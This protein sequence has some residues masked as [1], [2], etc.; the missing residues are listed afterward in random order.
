MCFDRHKCGT[1][2]ILLMIKGWKVLKGTLMIVRDRFKFAGL[3]LVLTFICASVGNAANVA[4]SI[5]EDMMYDGT[6]TAYAVWGNDPSAEIS[7]ARDGSR[8]DGIVWLIDLSGSGHKVND[9]PGWVF[10]WK[11]IHGPGMY[12]NLYINDSLH[13]T[14][15]SGW[16]EATGNNGI[17]DLDPFDNGI[18]NGVGIDYNEDNVYARVVK[19]I[20]PADE[21]AAGFSDAYAIDMWENGSIIGGST[22]ITPE[23]GEAGTAVFSYDV[24]L[25]SNIGV[26]Y[27][28]AAFKAKA[29]GDGTF[30]FDYDFS[31]FHSFYN[32]YADFKIFADGPDGTETITLVDY[33]KTY[34]FFSFTGSASIQI[35]HGYYFGFIVGGR[36][37]DS[38]SRLKGDLTIS[39]VNGDAD[40]DMVANGC[41]GCSLVPGDINC[42]NKVDLLDLAVIAEYWL[43]GTEVVVVP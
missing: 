20:L 18:S 8:T 21:C 34:S 1:E 26:S 36:N 2:D 9:D 41:D 5:Y 27:R 7:V 29:F 19:A 11:D 31:G 24:D 30:S 15:E 10:S 23:N 13:L 28:T 3:V 40:S 17:F 16:P 43:E 33:V 35:Y 38:N 39:N 14:L 4:F 42:D 32:A 37:Q 12:N 6:R 22:W 25:G